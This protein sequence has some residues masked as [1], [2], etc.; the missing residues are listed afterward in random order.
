MRESPSLRRRE[1]EPREA[2]VVLPP[3]ELEAVREDAFHS[4]ILSTLND[5]FEA[6]LEEAGFDDGDIRAIESKIAGLSFEDA[7]AVFAVPASISAKKFKG[8]RDLVEKGSIS[9]EDIPE[10]LLSEAH[11][12]G[13]GIGYHNAVREI[14]PDPKT[15]DWFVRPTEADHRDGDLPRAYYATSY[16]TLYR[17]K[18]SLKFLYVVRT[19]KDMAKTDGNWSRTNALSIIE[20]VP[21][22]RIDR[23]VDE[24]VENRRQ[25]KAKDA[26]REE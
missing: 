7:T 12:H 15:G 23:W 16:K 24:A 4:I 14:Q 6:N 25:L 13:F 22:E 8:L 2:A 18:H 11:E 5:T 17:S 10:R 3:E 21:L 19:I 9:A 20:E 26:T 1:I